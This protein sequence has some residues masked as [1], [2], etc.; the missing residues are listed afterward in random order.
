MNWSS[1]LRT[2]LAIPAWVLTLCLAWV[3]APAVARAAQP[4]DLELVLAVDTSGS[5][6]PEE[7]RLQRDGY[8]AALV[9]PDVVRAIRSGRRGRIAATYVEWAGVSFERIIAPWAVIDGAA[10][11]R[12]FAETIDRVPVST[13][14][15]TSISALIDF[16]VPLFDANDVEG[17]RHVIDISG[18][19][20]NNRGRLVTGARDDAVAAGIAINGLAIINDRPGLYGGPPMPDLDLYYRACVIGGPRAFVVVAESFA[21][22]AAAIRRKLIFEIAGHTPEP[23]RLW[24]TAADR[25]PPPCDIGERRMRRRMQDPF[26][27]FDR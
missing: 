6:D 13:M 24:R 18:D 19:G 5:I 25:Q 16:A 12:A 2:L 21:A 9:H 22:F 7:A 4:V 27:N 8:L 1:S 15:W 20:P 17:R 26:F 11:A 14:P 23:A 3:G 10:S